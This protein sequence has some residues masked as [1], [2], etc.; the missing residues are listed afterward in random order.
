MG[1]L[2][3]DGAGAG[4]FGAGLTSEFQASAHRLQNQQL[5]A[6]ISDLGQFSTPFYSNDRAEYVER[7]AMPIPIR[8]AK[9]FMEELQFEI[10]EWLSDVKL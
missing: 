6:R 2:Y 4:L 5:S 8:V 10:D 7:F 9:N 1:S 3:P